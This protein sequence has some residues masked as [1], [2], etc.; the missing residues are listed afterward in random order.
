[1]TGA[2]AVGLPRRFGDGWLSRN[3]RDLMQISILLGGFDQDELVRRVVAAGSPD[4]TTNTATVD[5]VLG[6][7]YDEA[8]ADSK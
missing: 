3:A 6:E 5:R 2:T 1:M 8:H 7:M 4:R